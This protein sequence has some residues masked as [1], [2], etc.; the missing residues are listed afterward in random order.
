MEGPFWTIFFENN[1]P[2]EPKKT[3]NAISSGRWLKTQNG[4]QI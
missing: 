4:D 3:K 1:S 2:D